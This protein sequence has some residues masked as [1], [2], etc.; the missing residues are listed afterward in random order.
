MFSVLNLPMTCLLWN[1]K[2]VLVIRTWKSLR[3][4]DFF[5]L[6]SM[7]EL[8]LTIK[9]QTEGSLDTTTST[10]P[11]NPPLSSSPYP[12]PPN[13]LSSTPTEFDPESPR[14]TQCFSSGDFGVGSDDKSYR[15]SDDSIQWQRSNKGQFCF[16][17]SILMFFV[18][19]L[20]VSLLL[21]SLCIP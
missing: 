19:L 12:Y 2:D 1:K 5:G 17:F 18:F 3:L 8:L 14:L 20:R 15:S 10:P 16:F 21:W 6:V 4:K 11:P 9:E 13:P 7:G